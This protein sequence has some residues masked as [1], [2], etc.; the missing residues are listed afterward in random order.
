MKFKLPIFFIVLFF[1][2]EAK[3]QS[4]PVDTLHKYGI[5][6]LDRL[7]P[8]LHK[9]RRDELRSKMAPHSAALFLAAQE[10]NRAND[11]S[12]EYHQDPN[13]YYLTGHV[14][15]EAALLLTKEPIVV[16]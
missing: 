5:Y 6:D 12:Y 4:V 14:Q 1:S 13:F 8:E 7:T 10:K 2:I 11:V 9:S 16:N 3:S 15:P